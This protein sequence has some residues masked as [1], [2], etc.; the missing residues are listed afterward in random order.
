MNFKKGRYFISQNSFTY[1]DFY[2]KSRVKLKAEP[3][4][5]NNP[6]AF[7]IGEFLF[8]IDYNSGKVNAIE[9]GK[10][11][12]S[13]DVPLVTDTR[14]KIFW[15]RVNK[16]VFIL[17][18]GVVY[19]CMYSHGKLN[20][21]KLV[22]LDQISE[23]NLIS[24]YYD[25]KYKKL[26]LGSSTD[27]LKIVSLS[28]FVSS[29][30]N[31]SRASTVFYATQPYNDSCVITP[32]GEIYDRKGFVESKKFKKAIS[33]FLNYDR[34]GNIVTRKEQSLFIYNK[35]SAFTKF[36]SV[37][38]GEDTLKDLFFAGGL[39]YLLSVRQKKG[40][41]EFTG[42]LSIYEDWPGKTLRKDIFLPM[43]RQ[44]LY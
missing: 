29:K 40:S 5:R 38:T 22:Q 7:A 26:Y 6:A 21:S 9:E 43:N 23:T 8:S 35:E 36:H 17:N 28:D 4:Y 20:T 42:A 30:R 39:Y 41:T 37:S 13:Y 34:A 11:I 25:E 31:S 32:T 33:Y 27:G 19:T 15:N 16:Q 24:I 12:K 10:I 44:D 1:E 18:N 14:S 3:F 2:S